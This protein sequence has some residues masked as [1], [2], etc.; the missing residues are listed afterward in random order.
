MM[1]LNCIVIFNAEKDKILCC[2]RTKDP[3]KGLYN[4]VGGKVEP[5]EASVHAAYRELNEE[6]GISER[7]IKLFRLMDMTYYVD[8]LVLEIYVGQLT[9][10]PALT[11][12]INPLVWLPLT[13]DFTDMNRFAGEQDMAHIV[14]IALKH[15]LF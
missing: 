9:T 6:T 1:H 8:K 14:N 5:G 10:K 12:E 11:E 2:K 4:F 13:E 7:D 3:Y 15:P